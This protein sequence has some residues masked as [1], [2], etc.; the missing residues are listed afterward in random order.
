[1]N[2]SY[3]RLVLVR[4]AAC[5]WKVT[6]HFRYPP[7][8]LCSRVFVFVC[9][10][11]VRNA[12]LPCTFTQSCCKHCQTGLH[13]YK[14]GTKAYFVWSSVVSDV[15]MQYSRTSCLWDLAVAGC[16]SSLKAPWYCALN[17]SLSEVSW[18]ER[19]HCIYKHSDNCIV[20]DFENISP[21]SYDEE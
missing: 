9:V 11:V 7:Q 4:L 15:G 13:C 3:D 1:M 17:S 5:C 18:L 19:F 12:R 8:L 10:C 2:C 16:D 6:S 20:D 14:L 21:Y